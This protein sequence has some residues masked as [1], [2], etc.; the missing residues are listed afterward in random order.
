[1][2]PDHTDKNTGGKQMPSFCPFSLCVL[3]AVQ[4]LAAFVGFAQQKP[5]PATTGSSIVNGA[6]QKPSTDP[7]QIG[8]RR[9]LFVDRTLIERLDGA[10]LKLH[11]PVSGGTAIRIDKP[12]E[13]PAN[14]GMSEIGRAHV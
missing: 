8:S 13:G 9:E 1:M 4:L 10:F 14:F 3:V 11:E 7:I 6:T 5:P 12:S 2:K